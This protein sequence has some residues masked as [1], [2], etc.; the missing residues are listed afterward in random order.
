MNF[1]KKLISGILAASGFCIS[2]C[3]QAQENIPWYA[4]DTIT[5]IA[6]NGYGEMYVWNFDER[7]N[8]L[9]I[10]SVSVTKRGKVTPEQ[11]IVSHYNRF[12][13]VDTSVNYI[14]DRTTGEYMVNARKISTYDSQGN[15]I[16]LINE[17]YDKGSDVWI[18]DTRY[19]STYNEKNLKTVELVEV[20]DPSDSE[21]WVYSQK[22]EN[23]YDEKDRLIAYEVYTWNGASWM[24]YLS[25]FDKYENDLLVERSGKGLNAAGSSFVDT[26]RYTNTYNAAGKLELWV[27]QTFMY[28]E[29]ENAYRREYF[30]DANGFDTMLLS[31]EWNFYY[32]DQWD[33]TIKEI[34][35]NDPEGRRASVKHYSIDG[36]PASD[37]WFL[38]VEMEYEYNEAGHRTAYTFNDYRDG[39][40]LYLYAFELNENNDD[41][42]ATAYIKKGEEWL[43]TNRYNLEVQYHDGTSILYANSA[44]HEITVHY[45]SGIKTPFTTDNQTWQDMPDFS[46]NVWPNPAR[47]ILSVDVEESGCFNMDLFDLSGRKVESRRAVQ[48]AE[49]NVAEYHGI[50][51]LRVEKNGAAAVQKVI[52]L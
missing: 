28:G 45:K 9:V 1:T 11:K 5:K 37:E 42:R 8:A 26:Y 40:G 31:Y 30:Y 43:P 27:Y 14:P 50:Y 33:C 21:K 18:P 6:A 12:D 48:H 51:L 49:F 20:P 2:V 36:A 16:G 22:T 46:I 35:T 25:T 24:P 4:P 13:L 19:T 41:V 34:Y 39:G 10:E 52:I 47:E 32:T 23:T 3:T 15:H 17:S 38:A 29:W 44:A 7:G